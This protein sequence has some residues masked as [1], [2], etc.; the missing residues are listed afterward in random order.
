M[1]WRGPAE[2]GEFPTLGYDIGE[3]IES[4]VVIPDGYRRGEPYLL[5]DEMWRFLLRFYRLEPD[6]G[7][8]VYFG[9]QLRR[10]QKWG[11]DPFGAAI[12]LAE[13]LGPARFDG[14]D[15]AGEPVGAPY[16]TPYIPILGVSEEQ[17][18]NTYTPLLDMIRLGPLIDMAGMDAGE[19]R[20][21]LP[22]GGTVEPVTSSPKSRLGQRM[23]FATLTETHLWLPSSGGRKLAAAVKR[24]IAGMDGRWLELTNGWDPS[25]HSEAQAT[26]EG[27]ERRVYVD[28][29]ESTHVE[30]LEN[31]VE[32]RR[33]LL[34]QYG[35]SALERGGW[36]NLDRITDEIR[37]PRT[38]EAD[39]RRFFL[40]EIVVGQSQF[41][42]PTR[43]A[44]MQREG[45]LAPRDSIALGFDGS[46][47][48][49]ATALWAM[50]KDG[51]LFKVGYWQRPDDAP[52]DWRVPSAEVD[53]VV[54][55]TFAGYDVAVMFADPWK[56]Q[57]YLDAWAALFPNRVVEFPTNKELRMD[58]AIERF[59]DGLDTI[60]HDGD[61]TLTQHIDDT[62]VTKG[63]RK[64]PRDGDEMNVE[65]HYKRLAK[66]K[67]TVKIDATVAAVLACEARGWA[68][69]HGA[70]SDKRQFWG[71]WA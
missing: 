16:P 30:D 71:A 61:E 55:D 9:G 21:E 64:R 14:W 68:L 13:A 12:V 39:G 8:L 62:V 43:W 52:A 7:S 63:S 38:L 42:A 33:E 5:T 6:A 27:K 1:P 50:R 60:T 54:R 67:S 53:K 65:Q 49:D 20:T 46:K 26:G 32:L 23:T 47:T 11:K 51:R 2:A 34:R 70:W 17:T 15:A 59:L 41:V 69:E 35:D 22:N 45:S 37:S 36:V 24:N 29:V 66:K 40:N 58:G 57:D 56:W 25:E 48:T 44:A 28:N 18:A 4:H 3:W 19:T 31:D 10:S